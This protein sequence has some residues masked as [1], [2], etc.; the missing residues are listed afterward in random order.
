M[1]GETR[2]D[3]GVAPRLRI[4]AKAAW[5]LSR[6]LRSVLPP[7]VE[8]VAARASI[9]LASMRAAS[10][11]CSEPVRMDSAPPLSCR[12]SAIASLLH[13]VAPTC[14]AGTISTSDVPR[15]ES[16]IAAPSATFCATRS[17]EITGRVR[18]LRV[19]GYGL[20]TLPATH[21]ARTALIST[22]PISVGTALGVRFE[23]KVV[24]VA[25][26][27]TPI[28]RCPRIAGGTLW[29]CGAP[30][31]LPEPGNNQRR[32][33]GRRAV[34]TP[35]ALSSQAAYIGD[36]RINRQAAMPPDAGSPA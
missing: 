24:S 36:S 3:V 5:N 26:V 15:S 31:R 33:P 29:V 12:A 32:R 23:R 35:R 21:S 2:M 19:V 11:A 25:I 28:I 34:L 1:L 17:D 18:L 10:A 30:V 20:A 6:S 7:S 27:A 13:L 14:F 8:A 16:V 9:M 22:V 4:A